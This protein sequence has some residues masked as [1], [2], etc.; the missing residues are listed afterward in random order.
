MT[1][2]EMHIEVNQGL[3]KVAANTTRKFL[4]EEIDWVLNKI[5]DRFIRSC[6][7]PVELEK[8]NGRYTFVD[9]IRA[10]SIKTL[11]VSNLQLPAYGDPYWSTRQKAILPKDY[12]YLLSDTSEIALLCAKPLTIADTTSTLTLLKLVKTNASN[13]PY[14]ASG[15]LDINGTI[16][17]IPADL[18]MLATYAGFEAKE[19]VVLLVDYIL[20]YFWKKG[21]EVYW[22]KYGEVH[23][24]GNFIIPS[25]S[26]ASI[27]WDSIVVTSTS[28]QNYVHRVLNANGVAT[29]TA[30]NRLMPSAEISTY[31][32]TPFFGTSSKGLISELSTNLLYIYRDNNCTVKSVR[33]SYIRKPQPISLLLGSDC[34]LS[35]QV[36]Q[37]ICDLTVEYL[38]KVI[39]SPTANLKTQDLET[40]V[41]F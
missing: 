1:S 15:V 31:L 37:L 40:R 21:I 36:H 30:D 11:V 34:E 26:S 17:N 35:S 38:K 4:T 14:Y 6:L 16:L 7:R 27:T 22:E 9:Q 18:G 41:I 19:E 8:F 3:Q 32:N 5:Q 39:E 20:N 23:S 28:T 24:Q 25:A 29:L 2:L 13:A 12:T 10:D 33:I